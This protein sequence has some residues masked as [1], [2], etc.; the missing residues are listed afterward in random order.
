MKFLICSALALALAAPAA[1]QSTGGTSTD[2]STSTHGGAKNHSD[3]TSK[4]HGSK[5]NSAEQTTQ[6]TDV[7]STSSTSASN[8]SAASDN[9]ATSATAATPADPA[10]GAAATP[11]SP[12]TPSGQSASAAAPAAGQSNDPA[13]ILKTEFPV[14]DKDTSGA[15]SKD[16]FSTWLLALKNA[17]P[18]QTPMTDAQQTEWLGKAFTE[19]D[20]DKSSTITLAELTTYLTRG[21]K[22]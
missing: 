12:A 19:A 3:K 15:L 13:T 4:T 2:T 16:E 17:A 18:Q 5:K 11:A 20:A 14:Y 1:A 21:A 7:G 6:D 22:G 9:A 8:A 10:S